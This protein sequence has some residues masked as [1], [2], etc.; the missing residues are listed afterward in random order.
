[1][2]APEVD[3]S[4][5]DGYADDHQRHGKGSVGQTAGLED[6]ELVALRVG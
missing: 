1:M 3:P 6:A 2:H 4:R 5:Q